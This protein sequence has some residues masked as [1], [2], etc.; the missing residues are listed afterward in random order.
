MIFKNGLL[1]GKPLLLPP[2]PVKKRRLVGVCSRCG[3]TRGFGGCKMTGRYVQPDGSV[4]EL[5][6]SCGAIQQHDGG[7]F[8]R[9][10]ARL[11][12]QP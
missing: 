8:D 9:L 12:K 5:C 2:K 10:M 3:A 6:A 7:K 1:G 4:R 11:N